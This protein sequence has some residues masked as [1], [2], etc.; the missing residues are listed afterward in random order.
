MSGRMPGPL[1][2]EI[3]RREVWGMVMVP[4]LLDRPPT[5]DPPSS[6]RTDNAMIDR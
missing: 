6:E 3:G 2:L 4:E 1:Q 5:P